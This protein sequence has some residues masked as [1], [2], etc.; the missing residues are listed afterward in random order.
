MSK[1]ILIHKLSQIVL[2]EISNIIE[3]EVPYIVDMQP[4]K[5]AV[6]K[7]MVDLID[8]NLIEMW[9]SEWRQEMIMAEK[10]K[11]DVKRNM[12]LGAAAEVCGRSNAQALAEQVGEV[13]DAISDASPDSTDA[14]QCACRCVLALI[15]LRD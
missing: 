9:R 7:Q 2:N 10:A 3:R 11:A 12:E 13:F 5:V 15:N 1:E 14:L 8:G 6:E 4:V